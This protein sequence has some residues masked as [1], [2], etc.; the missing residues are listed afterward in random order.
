MSKP[1]VNSKDGSLVVTVF[2]PTRKAGQI[3]GTVAMDMSISKVDENVK[4]IKF[5]KTGKASLIT[6]NGQFIS[7]SKYTANDNINSIDGGAL[8]SL[9]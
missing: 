9:S 7:N 1:Y 3:V 2:V 4:E 8:S 6:A 5:F